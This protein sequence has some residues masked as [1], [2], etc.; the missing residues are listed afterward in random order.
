MKSQNQQNR[1]NDTDAR[2]KACGGTQLGCRR[3]AGQLAAFPNFDDM[4]LKVLQ[5]L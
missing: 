3:K 5:V 1:Q 4:V 2:N